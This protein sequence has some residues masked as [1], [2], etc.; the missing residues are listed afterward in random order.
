M[1]HVSGMIILLNVYVANILFTMWSLSQSSPSDFLL[2]LSSKDRRQYYRS[3]KFVQ[4]SE[5]PV[6]SPTAG[7][8]PYISQ[9]HCQVQ[10]GQSGSGGE[11]LL[12]AK[13]QMHLI[14]LQIFNHIT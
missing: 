1:Y 12:D 6:W 7:Q 9:S 8:T 4:L 5:I 10:S 13:T 14:E 2:S 11:T 3:S